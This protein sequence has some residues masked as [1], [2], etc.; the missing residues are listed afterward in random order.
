MDIIVL[1]I[2]L[3]FVYVNKKHQRLKITNQK[4]IP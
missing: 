1:T 3:K 2:C 4:E